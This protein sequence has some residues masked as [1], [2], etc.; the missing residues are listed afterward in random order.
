M[1]ASK[2]IVL[3]AA[4]TLFGCTY[5]IAMPTLSVTTYKREY[6]TPIR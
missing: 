2:D 4:V 1:S 5:R 3:A 6:G